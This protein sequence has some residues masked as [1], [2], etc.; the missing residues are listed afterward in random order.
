MADDMTFALLGPVRMWR[1][2][3]ELPAGSPQQRALAAMLLLHQ[4]RVV[5]ID[6][7]ATALWRDEPPR[8]A[9]GTLRTYVSRLRRL[10]EG[11]TATI[12]TVGGGY[13]LRTPEDS[14]DVTRFEALLRRGRELGRTTDLTGAATVLTQA[15]DLWQGDGLDGVPGAYAAHQR[16]RL[17][18]ERLAATSLRL[19]ALL[20]SG[21]SVVPEL[22]TLVEAHPYREELR[23]LLMRA[24]YRDGRQADAI[25]AYHTGARLLGDELGLDPGPAL[26]DMHQR[27]L[28]SD[29]TLTVTPRTEPDT[30]VPDG[31]V[32]VEQ[33][34]VPQPAQLP[35]DQ[36]G[37]VGRLR[38]LTWADALLDARTAPAT[39]VISGM[40]G[41]GKSTLAV[42]WAHH[43]ATAFPDGQLYVDLRGFDHAQPPVNPHDALIRLL[44][45]LGIAGEHVPD[46]LDA[47]SA[48][49]R[50]VL[51]DR[52]MLVLLDNARD[53][54][55]VRPLL[56]GTGDSLAL[57]TSRHRLSALRVAGAASIHL[58]VL[59][60]DDAAALLT[61][62]SGP[63]RAD[64]DP[65]SLERIVRATGRLP[66]ALAVVG[67]R[68]ADSPD[69]PL[70]V[71]AD[72]LSSAHTVLDSLGDPDP[73][74]DVRAVLSWSCSALD[75]G[76][77]RALRQLAVLPEASFDTPAARSAVADR[78]LASLDTLVR[79]S[80]LARTRPGWY[81]F[82]DLVRTFAGELAANEPEA[83]R[84]TVAR[85][86]DHYLGSAH[87]ATMA[88]EP[89]RV[90]LDLPVPATGTEIVRHADAT[91]AFGWLAGHRRTLRAAVDVAIAERLD[92]TAWQLAWCLA[93]YLHRAG[94]WS[95]AVSLWQVA[96][97]AAERDVSVVGRARTHQ[98]LG[99]A[100]G[101]SQGMS[102]AGLYPSFTAPDGKQVA[103]RAHVTEAVRLFQSLGMQT[104]A[105]WA[106][107][108][109]ASQHDLSTDP[110]AVA[111]ALER[112]RQLSD[113]PS[114]QTATLNN[115]AVLHAR[116][117]DGP[118]AVAMAREVL[119]LVEALDDTSTRAH[120]TDTLGMAQMADDDPGAAA[121]S[122]REAARIFEETGDPMNQGV[123][124]A[125]LGDAYAAAGD[126]ATAQAA[127]AE[128]L[129]V[130]DGTG[131]PL[132]DR[133]QALVGPKAELA[134]PHR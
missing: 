27:I 56:P 53:A 45:S 24:L 33:T 19:A 37:F 130:L 14:V 123:S 3:T 127:R 111:D 78:D 12:D 75:V 126:P 96:L 70:R 88:L 114:L 31:S 10:L 121:A 98:G 62:L 11:T 4:G 28:V 81:A 66:L 58:D 44:E 109:L 67:A 94:Y 47:R 52:R 80:L 63:D 122:F 113:E 21:G 117:G 97:G 49:Y 73:T 87:L 129:T 55:Q 13:A 116:L 59:P 15:L 6:E 104:A 54:D 34:R 86:M 68:L 2:G 36:R 57:V 7:M 60:D 132:V 95:D 48:L 79:A 50:S 17:Q 51:A 131:H 103:A 35:A 65:E 72:E 84:E 42:H 102:A 30:A 9:F 99:V 41:V 32:R 20:D 133:L 25:D 38:E 26:R 23:A 115:L 16:V 105:A 76:A 46:S 5:S 85:V 107:L 83:R 100:I 112:A 101:M 106:L 108:S 61:H 64:A 120:A 29:P 92:G 1:A 124:L 74:V 90:P 8:G 119:D 69:T 40:G 77:R 134:E 22:A 125:N 118:R 128:A 82:H 110:D 89:R 93:A 43:N 18:E 71:I 39:A 91:D